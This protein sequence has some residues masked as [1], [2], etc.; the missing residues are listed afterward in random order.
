M[1]IESTWLSVN[2]DWVHSSLSCLASSRI[3]IARE[4]LRDPLAAFEGGKSFYNSSLLSPSSLY[5][6]ILIKM[7]NN[8]WFSALNLILG[9]WSMLA[10][11]T[12]YTIIIKPN[13]K[14]NERKRDPRRWK[15]DY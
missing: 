10:L 11:I 13:N 14:K 3:R 7:I 1:V 4:N 12:T 2:K 15:G 8:S 9:T 6:K 5:D